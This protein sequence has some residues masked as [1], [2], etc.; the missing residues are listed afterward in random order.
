MKEDMLTTTQTPQNEE[1][2]T[3]Q[4]VQAE[5]TKAALEVNRTTQNLEALA[6]LDESQTT[7][8]GQPTEETA[9]NASAW[10]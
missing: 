10:P 7:I 5:S 4:E 6:Q 8:S 2:E 9:A 3:P 1:P